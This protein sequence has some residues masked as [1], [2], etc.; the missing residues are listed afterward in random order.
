MPAK[1]NISPIPAPGP[2][3]TIGP[4]TRASVLADGASVEDLALVE[5]SVIGRGA[6]VQSD[7]K[8]T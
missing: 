2:V 3:P 8:Q 4:K 5:A 7:E 1:T 6:T